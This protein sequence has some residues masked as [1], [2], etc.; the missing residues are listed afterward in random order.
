MSGSASASCYARGVS[1]DRM[2]QQWDDIAA[3][4]EQ[5]PIRILRGTESDI[6][7]GGDLDLPD[8]LLEQLDV[9]IASVHARHRLDHAAMTARLVRALSLP[10]FKIWGHALGRILNQREAIDC[11]VLAVLDALA[12][13]RGAIE[14]N[15]D[16]HRLDLPSSWIPAARE[17]GIPFVISVDAQSVAGFEVLPYGI[18]LARRGNVRKHEVLNTQ[19]ADAFAAR[20]K[21]V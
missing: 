12:A 14:L 16:P 11:D 1:I 7:L 18:T 8:R 20:V 21:P 3:A 10:I 9:V 4:E 17:R 5:V 13:S 15:A 6:L 19:S 2:K